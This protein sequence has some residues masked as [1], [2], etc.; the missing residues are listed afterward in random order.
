MADAERLRL[1][2]LV[3]YRPWPADHGGKI[4]AWEVLSRLASRGVEI[5]VWYPASNDQA[6][7]PREIPGLR[8]NSYPSRLQSGRARKL[9]HL[10]GG[11]PLS[12]RAVF[13]RRSSRAVASAA[14]EYDAVVLEQAYQGPWVGALP[15]D[16]AVAVMA[17]NIEHHLLAQV[18]KREHSRLLR[19][20]YRLDARKFRRVERRLFNRA[21]LICVVSEEDLRLLSELGGDPGARVTVRPNGVDLDGFAFVPPRPGPGRRLVLTGSLGYTP[22][23]DAAIWI[24]DEILPLIRQEVPDAEIAVVGSQCPRAL[25]DLDDPG[26]GFNVIGYVDEVLPYLR[27]ADVFLMPLR[28]GGGTRLKALQAMAAGIPIVSTAQGVEG[29]PLTGGLDVSLGES[30][31]DIAAACV[32]LLEDGES[33]LE[34]AVHARRLA[35][36]GYG[37]EAIVRDIHADLQGISRPPGKG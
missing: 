34:Q 11:L 15:E 9:V 27:E 23:C 20:V 32:R 1:L 17:H 24:R 7:P 2:W 31:V 30:A 10:A 12:V 36:S 22:N 4:R 3:P 33:R 35:A 21:N 26:T 28:I 37:W 18:A 29:I 19:L 6:P 5:D 14:H 8:W 13:D 16:V 25:M